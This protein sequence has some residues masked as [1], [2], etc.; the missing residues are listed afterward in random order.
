VDYCYQNECVDINGDG[1]IIP[2]P[3]FVE[4][5]IQNDSLLAEYNSAKD[6]INDFAKTLGFALNDDINGYVEGRGVSGLTGPELGRFIE[7]GIDSLHLLLKRPAFKVAFKTPIPLKFTE[8]NFQT[9]LNQAP[10]NY[11]SH[12]SSSIQTGVRNWKNKVAFKLLRN[13]VSFSFG[14]DKQ[15]KSPW[16]PES[17]LDG[18]I[19]RSI[20]DTKSGSIGLGFRNWPGLNYSMRLQER[21]DLSVHIDS[22]LSL[23]KPIVGQKRLSTHTIAPTYKM[24][25]VDIGI[26]MNGNITFVNDLDELSDTT[27]CYE[28]LNSTKGEEWGGISDT[29]V[30]GINENFFIFKGN[31]NYPFKNSGAQTSTYTGAFSFSF[32]IP[33]SLNLGWG[34]STNTPNDF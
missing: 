10:L 25:I 7:G 33:L 27:G 19:K 31:N 3:E 18:E 21:K 14:Y 6:K 32:P 4:G 20:T 12:G 5:A 1:I 2:S 17:D 30:C 11:L 24:N 16:D 23:Q 8:L 15:I 26:S 9:E 28:I 29:S 13:Q 22:T 34:M